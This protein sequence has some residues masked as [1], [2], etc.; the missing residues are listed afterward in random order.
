[1]ISETRRVIDRGVLLLVLTVTLAFCLH[2]VF[3][4]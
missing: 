1:M 3:F 4:L 2:M